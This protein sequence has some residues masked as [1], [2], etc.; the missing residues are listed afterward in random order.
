MSNEPPALMTFMGRIENIETMPV[1]SIGTDREGVWV[2]RC[3]ECGH[4]SR[5][6]P[7]FS[8][9]IMTVEAD[10]CRH[11]QTMLPLVD[12]VPQRG[13]GKCGAHFTITHNAIIRHNP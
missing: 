2:Y 8:G 3:P 12:T 4:R 7:G 9:H 11:W 10:L 6:G 5:F 1:G 13:R